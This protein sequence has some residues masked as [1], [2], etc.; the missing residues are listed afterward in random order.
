M[1]SVQCYVTSS[2]S[3]Q[4]K[5]M[6]AVVPSALDHASKSSH[7][8]LPADLPVWDSQINKQTKCLKNSFKQLDQIFILKQN[9]FLQNTSSPAFSFNVEQP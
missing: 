6:Y 8:E 1:S 7:N 2:E 3:K 5:C 4:M 9:L